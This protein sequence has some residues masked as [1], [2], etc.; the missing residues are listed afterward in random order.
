[1]VM[2][3]AKKRRRDDFYAD[4]EAY[5]R[6]GDVVLIGE[7]KSITP[8]PESANQLVSYMRRADPEIPFGLLAD[9][10]NLAIYRNT[11]DDSVSRVASINTAEVVRRYY[12]KYG[13][14]RVFASF[15]STLLEA[16]L[17]DLA[18]HSDSKAP[19]AADQIEAIGLRRLLEGGTIEHEVRLVGYS[20][21]WN[22]F[23]PELRDRSRPGSQ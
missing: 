23:H 5:D 3:T 15:L 16:W 7:V 20:V 22:E 2:E 13:E 19:P 17:R 1:M 9:P 11:G 12:A 6:E 14:E 8:H 10:E 21:R 18:R 4:F